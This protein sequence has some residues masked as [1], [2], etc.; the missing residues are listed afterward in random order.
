[1]YPDLP[2]CHLTPPAQLLCGLCSRRMQGL[3]ANQAPYYRC[4]FP[5]EYAL[6]NHVDHPRNVTLR[7]DA[8]L[9]PL[10]DWL[11]SKFGSAHLAATVDELA[12]A[13]AVPSGMGASREDIQ[14]ARN[15]RSDRI[16][17]RPAWHDPRR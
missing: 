1:M 8:I 14:S 15:G 17:V 4:R 5:S 7:Q 13:V 12:A 2:V 16:P 3:W 6:A 9:G 10:D 11:A